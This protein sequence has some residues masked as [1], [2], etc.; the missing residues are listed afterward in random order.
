MAQKTQFKMTNGIQSI[1]AQPDDIAALLAAGYHMTGINYSVG[2]EGADAHTQFR[3]QKG[4][5]VIHVLAAD[6]LTYLAAGYAVTRILYGTSQVEIVLNGA[7]LQVIDAPDFASAEIGTVADT[8]VAVTFTSGVA[9]ADFKAG[10]VIQVNGAPVTVSTATR[11]AD[12][13]V[14][15]YVITPAVVNGDT[16]TWSYDDATGA[17]LSAADGSHLDDVTNAAV[18][19]NVAP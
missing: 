3:M 5:D 14:V 13:R 16:V 2:G 1:N 7:N 18:T 11:Q 10:V 15:H 6:V 17:I 12:H 19:N 9:S 4:A 8:K